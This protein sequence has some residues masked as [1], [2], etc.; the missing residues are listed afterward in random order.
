M[1]GNAILLAPAELRATYFALKGAK[2]VI[3]VEPHPGTFREML[4][5]IKLNNLENVAVPLAKDYLC[6]VVKRISKSAGMVYCT[7][8]W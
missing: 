5:N 1:A 8:N 2:K 3:A 7:R 4:D 6:K